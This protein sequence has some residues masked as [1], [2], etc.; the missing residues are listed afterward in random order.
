MIY[1]PVRV[2]GKIDEDYIERLV[3][4]SYGWNE[5]RETL[6]HHSA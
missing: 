5:V 6:A 4:N 1:L 2:D 3:V